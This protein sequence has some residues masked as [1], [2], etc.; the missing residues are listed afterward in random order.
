[1]RRATAYTATARPGAR[2]ARPLAKAH[3][4]GTIMLITAATTRGELPLDPYGE[5]MAVHT[6]EVGTFGTTTFPNPDDFFR[7]A[8]YLSWGTAG[9]ASLC[10]RDSQPELP[11]FGLLR[12]TQ[13][14]QCRLCV[15]CLDAHARA[16]STDRERRLIHLHAV[17]L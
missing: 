10:R 15:Q 7:A 13:S 2:S 3:V 16:E 17:P 11:V 12:G 9:R 6:F 5:R 4:V 14:A 1:C 8:R